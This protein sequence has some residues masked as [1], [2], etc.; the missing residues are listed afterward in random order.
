MSDRRWCSCAIH[1]VW[2]KSPYNPG[3]NACYTVNLHRSCP[4]CLS[5][6]QSQLNDA[7]HASRHVPPLRERTGLHLVDATRI[8]LH[9]SVGDGA[10]VYEHLRDLTG[11]ERTERAEAGYQARMLAVISPA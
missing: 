3:R 11:V 7:Q 5:A 6:G 1:T 9:D 8:G 2:R 10:I 4:G